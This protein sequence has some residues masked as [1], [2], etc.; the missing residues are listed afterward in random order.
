[1]VRKIKQEPICSNLNE[2]Y[3]LFMLM[4]SQEIKVSDKGTPEEI[5]GNLLA[6]L[7]SHRAM[8][9]IL[10]EEL[11]MLENKLNIEEKAIEEVKK[12]SLR[13]MRKYF[14]ELIDKSVEK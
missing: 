5:N 4:K 9:R 14:K 3:A 11:T 8:F 2:L 13:D 6:Q 7:E 10:G 1:M 12:E